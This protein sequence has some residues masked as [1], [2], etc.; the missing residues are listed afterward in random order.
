MKLS[1]SVLFFK[2][3]AL[4]QVDPYRINCNSFV[5]DCFTLVITCTCIFYGTNEKLH[6]YFTDSTSFYRRLGYFLFVKASVQYDVISIA[7]ITTL[8]CKQNNS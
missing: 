7:K 4:G 2:V 5:V 3:T 1:Y 8:H 6:S